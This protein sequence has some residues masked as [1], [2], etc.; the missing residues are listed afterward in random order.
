MRASKPRRVTLK[1]VAAAARVAPA[2]ASY[3]IN[4]TPGQTVRPETRERVLAAVAELG[5]I[6]DAN[7]RAMRKGRARCVGVVIRKD[8]S[9]PRFA[10]TLQGIQA[11]LD[12][13]G[14]E[15]MLCTNRMRSS[16]MADYIEAFLEHRVD[17]VIF[18]GKD[19]EGP[20]EGSLAVVRAHAIPFVIYDCQMRPGTY[21]SVE[22]DYAVGACLLMERV[23][24]AAPRHLLYLRPDIDKA[25]EMER[26]R[27][28]R[29]AMRA[30]PETELRVC[31]VPVTLDNLSVW[32][33]R[34]SVGNDAKSGELTKRFVSI[35]RQAASDLS[36][37]DAVVASWSTWTDLFRRFCAEDGLIFGELAN[38]GETRFA[39]GFYTR[40]PNVEVGRACAELLLRLLAGKPPEARVIQLND[41][42]DTVSRSGL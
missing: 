6:P 30:H 33:A 36:K 25:Q 14:I 39:P 16:G 31:T 12:E 4:E 10:Q 5:Y 22:L 24:T 38:N 23:L 42:I 41:I 26:E 15:T 9:V 2:T 1:D 13:A 19:N 17:G 18:L 7:A 34:Y 11:R 21:S 32:D 29:E 20:D 40:L 37:G 35:L 28:V 27:G 3:V 8:L